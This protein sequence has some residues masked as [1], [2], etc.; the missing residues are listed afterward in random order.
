MSI[1]FRWFKS[2]SAELV[3]NYRCWYLDIKYTDKGSTSHS[4]GNVIKVEYLFEK[5]NNTEFPRINKD[6]MNAEDVFPNLI[7]PHD[8]SQMCQKVWDSD[9]PELKDMEDRFEWFK[10][11]SE[12]GFYIAYET[13]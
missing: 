9:D 2:C 6:A 8:M 7:N 4:A 11:L 1:M 3:E 13:Y 10:E 5:Y 12:K